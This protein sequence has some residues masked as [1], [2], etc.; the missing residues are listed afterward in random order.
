MRKT[1][2]LIGGTMGVGKTTVCKALKRQLPHSVLLDGDWC[3]DAHPFTVTAETKAMVVDNICHLLNN[4]IVC[5]AYENVIFCWVMH[6][7]SIIEE[8]LKNL[9]IAA[10]RVWEFSL[11]ADVENLQSRLEKDIKNGM[12][13]PEIVTKSLER[14]PLYQDLNTIKIDTSGKDVATVVKEIIGVCRQTD[15][16][17]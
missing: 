8:I 12:R 9:N 16:E 17:I 5:S 13:C 7:Q 1:L 4:F 3:W 6:E 15:G 10:C 11:V 2:Y 14:L